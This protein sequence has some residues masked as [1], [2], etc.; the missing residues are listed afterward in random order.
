MP[1]SHIDSVAAKAAEKYDEL[2]Q[3][4][5]VILGIDKQYV[6]ENSH[7]FRVELYPEG[8]RVYYRNDVPLFSIHQKVD[9]D[10][11]GHMVTISHEIRVLTDGKEVSDE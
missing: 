10:L 11:E 7:E 8:R 4:C 6:I 9:Q 1:Y 2:V 3:S 5:F